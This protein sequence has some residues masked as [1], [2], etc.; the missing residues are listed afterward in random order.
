MSA[1]EGKFGELSFEEC[2]DIISQMKEC[3][4]G[5]VSLTGGEPLV[6]RDFL[7]ILDALQSQEIMVSE[8]YTNGALVDKPLLQE[9]ENRKMVPQFSISFDGK[10]HHDW[11]RGIDGA[12]DRAVRAF[13]LLRSYG[14]RATAEMCVHRR[15]IYSIRDTVLLL[16]DL[17][18]RA[19]KI[20]PA[21][22][23]GLWK[24][25]GREEMIPLKELFDSYL[26]YIPQYFKDGAPMSIMLGGFFACEKGG[27]NYR[28]PSIKFNGTEDCRD[29][30]LCMSARENLY[31]AA[32]AKVLPCIS[33]TGLEVQ[34]DFPSLKQTPL[35]QILKE[36]HYWKMVSA[37]V[38]ELLK[39]NEECNGCPHRYRCGG[40]CRAGALMSSGGYFGKDETTCF[41]FR[42]GYPE[43]IN[44]IITACIKREPAKV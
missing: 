44:S 2:R 27:E 25:K 38:G 12:E 9:L 1:P 41:I 31:I 30:P 19:V 13:E 36:S 17:G 8:I 16:A 5:S 15:N 40:G 35:K 3:G 10:G 20:T 11:M 14:F 42:E 23:S 24:E 6:R 43:K 37:T 28:I 7:S 39:Q 21:S 29:V 22:P 32:D 33:M 34:A 4:I 18:V 26:E